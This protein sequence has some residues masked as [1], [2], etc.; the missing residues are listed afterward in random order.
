MGEI[1]DRD[2]NTMVC[3]CIQADN[4][5]FCAVSNVTNGLVGDSK[6]SSTKPEL[7]RYYHVNECLR[8]PIDI[9]NFIQLV[10]DSLTYINS[11]NLRGPTTIT[12]NSWIIRIMNGNLSKAISSERKVVE[13]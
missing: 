13:T 8:R 9:Y 7:Q 11:E 4:S 10:C 1:S 2:E 6:R 5:R 12:T 3:D